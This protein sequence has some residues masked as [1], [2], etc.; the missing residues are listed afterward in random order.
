MIV[1]LDSNIFWSALIS[2]GGAPD[3]IYGA[4]MNGRFDLLTCPE[5]IVEIR[6]ASRHPKLRSILQPARI[7]KMINN[8]L[9][10]TVWD[11]ALPKVHVAVDPTDSFLLNLIE[12]AQPDYAVTGD[13][14]SGLLTLRSLGRTRI[15]TAREF[16][17]Q[18]LRS[19]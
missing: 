10:A 19:S 1:L 3:R 18:V 13:H 15:L 16:C 12:A 17:D 9:R 5:Q 14:R 4:W 6:S 7:G 8:L 11:E 2:P